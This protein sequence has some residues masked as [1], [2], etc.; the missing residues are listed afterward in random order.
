MRVRVAA[1]VAVVLAAGCGSTHGHPKAQTGGTFDALAARPGADVAIVAGD[2]DFAPGPIRFSFLVIDRR[3]KPVL[4][5]TADVWVATARDRR[6]FAHATA[7]LEPIGIPGVSESALGGVTSIYVTRFRVSRAGRYW[8]LAQPS[9]AKVQA[10]G[11]IDVKPHSASPPVGAK[12][13]TSATPTVRSAHGNLAA[14]TTRTPP[15]VSLLR[16]SVAGSLAAHK[17]F[18]VVFATPKFCESRT[19]GP[20]VDVTMRVQRDLGARVRFIHVEV[21][22]DNDPAKGYNAWMRQWHL[23]SEPWAF[24]VGRDGRIKAKFEG[25]F[26]VHEL[27]SAVRS[28]LL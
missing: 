13:P 1:L 10:L 5:R 26:S 28:S 11:T 3:A 7:R 19:C 23:L 8:V 25:S 9:R 2:G 21:Y 22:R 16:Y 18:V 15:D 27:E 12:A 17:P 14:L 20:V 6:P 24:L 4:R